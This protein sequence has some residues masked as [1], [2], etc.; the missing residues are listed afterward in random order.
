M[1]A[2]LAFSA[3]SLVRRDPDW[4]FGELHR[5]E[6]LVGCVPGAS[7]TRVTGD[8]SFDARITLGLGPIQSRHDGKVRIV[9]SNREAR[10]A[11]LEV[12][13]D[14]PS[15]LAPVRVLMSMAIVQRKIQTEIRMTFR[16]AMPD[17]TWLLLQAFI[18][19]IAVDLVA[20]T[21]RRIEQQLEAAPVGYVD[22][23]MV[24]ARAVP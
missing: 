18:E 9:A 19:P 23:R 16:V 17:R 13:C 10:T 15:P 12:T 21:A 3:V 8:R 24:A 11:A 5:P 20:R 14:P 7:L 22:L 1:T 6:T 4:I 2:A